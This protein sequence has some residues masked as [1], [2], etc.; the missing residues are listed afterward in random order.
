M[1][2]DMC[3]GKMTACESLFSPS[4]M[5]ILKMG[6]RSSGSVAGKESNF[7]PLSHLASLLKDTEHLR[8]DGRRSC[9]EFFT[10]V[11]QQII[12]SLPQTI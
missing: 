4:G 6:F 11:Y 1:Y 12:F 2:C 5:W 9:L 8:P 3:G 7:T 10:L